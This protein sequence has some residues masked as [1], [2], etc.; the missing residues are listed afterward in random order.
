MAGENPPAVLMASLTHPPPPPSMNKSIAQLCFLLLLA[1]MA[2]AWPPHPLSTCDCCCPPWVCPPLWGAAPAVVSCAWSLPLLACG[3][4]T[5]IS[6]LPTQFP[7]FNGFH[8]YLALM[9]PGPSPATV[10]Y[11]CPLPCVSLVQVRSLA[12]DIP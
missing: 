3:S 6:S 5:C 4:S 7:P 8:Q 12:P 10:S 2:P 9:A 11:S 1:H